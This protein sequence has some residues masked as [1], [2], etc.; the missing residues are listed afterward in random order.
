MAKIESGHAEWHNTDVDMR[1]ARRERGARRVRAVPRARRGGRAVLARPGAADPR[2]PRPADPGHAEPARPTPRSSFRPRAEGSRS[3]CAPTRTAWSS[4]SATTAPGCRRPSRRRCSRSSARAGMPLNRP[5]GTGTRPSD[6]PPDRRSFRRAHVAGIGAGRGRVL[7][8]PAAA[9]AEGGQGRTMSHKV[10]IADDE[11]NIVVSL[12]FMMK[13]EGYEVAGGARRPAGAGGDP[14][15]AAA[16]GAAR[17]D[18]ARHVG[19]RRLR[20]GARRRGSSATPG[21]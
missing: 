15:R 8:V 2:R 13:R 19:L 16:A 20:G 18:D 17:R 10:L 11:P 14:P 9:P 6:Q 12:E 5:P 3:C 4:R 1:D 7:R 21:S